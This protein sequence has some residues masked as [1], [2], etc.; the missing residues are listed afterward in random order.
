MINVYGVKMLLYTSVVFS[1]ISETKTGTENIEDSLVNQC[2][3]TQ[4]PSVLYL[5]PMALADCRMP[6]F[7]QHFDI[8][9]L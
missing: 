6:V 4:D 1:Q 8:A 5:R 2:M 3:C 9:K 7:E